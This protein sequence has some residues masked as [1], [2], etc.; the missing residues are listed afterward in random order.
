MKKNIYS[1]ISITTYDEKSYELKY[2]NSLVINSDI[3]SLT[4]TCSILFPMDNAIIDKKQFKFNTS[5]GEEVILT[6]RDSVQIE[7]AFYND[8][9]ELS[10]YL[11]DSVT[12]I[13]TFPKYFIGYI[14]GFNFSNDMIELKLEDSM[15]MF[16]R[17]K[18][19]YSSKQ[20]TM[21]E[22]M[23]GIINDYINSGEI[24]QLPLPFVQEYQNQEDID[25]GKLRIA[26]YIS[27]AKIFEEIKEKYRLFIYFKNIISK[28]G[29]YFKTIPHLFAGLKYPIKDI[30]VL[31]RTISYE[32]PYMEPDI[33]FFSDPDIKKQKNQTFYNQI[34]ENNLSYETFDKQ[35]DLIIVGSLPTDKNNVTIKI[36][37]C[38]ANGEM[39]LFTDDVEKLK[40][41]KVTAEKGLKDIIELKSTKIEI[42]NKTSGM[43]AISLVDILMSTYDNFQEAG[44]KGTIT[45]FGE[46]LVNIGDIVNLK[47]ENGTGISKMVE[48]SYYVDAVTINCNE[49]TGFTQ[50]ITIGS[51][52]NK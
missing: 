28:S 11:P 18:V 12:P 40:K 22:F 48:E 47:I 10:T 44:F 31:T 19:K 46:P 5:N 52:I 23:D 42:N 51:K 1:K 25:L 16:K 6:L 26:D 24:Y 45:V 41:L 13:K 14:S 38:Y 8:E 7:L 27:A 32:Y 15:N 20:V 29:S 36:G 21:K 4:S 3:N 39:K 50:T 2:F 49:S 17:K 43:S 37:Y 34:I 33:P 9:N 30:D 35:S